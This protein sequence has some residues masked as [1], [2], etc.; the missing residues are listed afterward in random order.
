MLSETFCP[1][2]IAVVHCYWFL[3]IHSVDTQ[4][5]VNRSNTSFVHSNKLYLPYFLGCLL[6]PHPAVARHYTV[7][8]CCRWCHADLCPTAWHVQLCGVAVHGL[9]GECALCAICRRMLCQTKRANSAVYVASIWSIHESKL[10]ACYI[11]SSKLVAKGNKQKV[12]IVM[13][14]QLI[15]NIRGYFKSVNYKLPSEYSYAKYSF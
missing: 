2:K 6:C 5:D 13:P 15:L 9:Q 8:T 12:L 1:I 10:E 7:M 11:D 14:Q 3:T 4:H